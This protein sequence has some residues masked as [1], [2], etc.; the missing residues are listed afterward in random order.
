MRLELIVMVV[1]ALFWQSDWKVDIKSFGPGH[2][3][4]FVHDADGLLW[5]FT[6]FYGN[7][8]RSL[9]HFSWELLRR[10]HSLS[11]LLWVIGGDFNEI[12]HLSEKAGGSDRRHPPC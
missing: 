8:N 5:R 11:S 3:D 4:S 12:I 9:H 7:P 6:R 10:L 2:I 1:I